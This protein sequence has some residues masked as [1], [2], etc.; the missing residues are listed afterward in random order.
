MPAFIRVVADKTRA[1]VGEQVTVSWSLYVTS[2]PSRFG[3]VSEPH[4]DGFW[5]EDIPSTTPPGRLAFGEQQTIA[6]RSYNVAL[7][8][9]KAL[10]PL[11]AGK[12]TITPMEAELT[13]RPTSSARR[14]PR[15]SRPSR[16]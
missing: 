1:F 16:W 6:G 3:Q 5:S 10:F 8:F 4:T 11:R 14:G 15:A 2:V 12:L 7:L 9:K 13:R